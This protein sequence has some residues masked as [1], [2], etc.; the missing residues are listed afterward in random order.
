MVKLF[1]KIT[2]TNQEQGKQISNLIS[3]I[4]TLTKILVF[5]GTIEP[6]QDNNKK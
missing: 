1:Q 2:K 3:Q 4:E 6:P 5:N